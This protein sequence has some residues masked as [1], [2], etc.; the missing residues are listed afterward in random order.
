MKGTADG[1]ALSGA[2]PQRPGIHAPGLTNESEERTSVGSITGGLS[3]TQTQTLGLML[4]KPCIHIASSKWAARA[5]EQPPKGNA[6]FAIGH[7]LSAEVRHGEKSRNTDVQ[8]AK[9]EQEQVHRAD[10]M[11]SACLSPLER[12]RLWT[13]VLSAIYYQSIPGAGQ[14]ALCT[15][16][17]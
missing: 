14:N 8:N 15:V 1:S 11:L 7:R 13:G 9:S 16:C 10:F 17:F 5:E 6:Y 2:T 4:Q 12:K 3:L